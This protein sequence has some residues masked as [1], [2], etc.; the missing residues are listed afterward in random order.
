M[1]KNKNLE[2]IKR[3]LT[4]ISLFSVTLVFTIS[5]DRVL[6]SGS[7]NPTPNSAGEELA[8]FEEDE[9]AAFDQESTETVSSLLH[10]GHYKASVYFP[11]R[12]KRS[13][14]SHIWLHVIPFAG[15]V[16]LAITTA[17]FF[18]RLRQKPGLAVHSAQ[19]GCND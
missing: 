6:A 1:N 16:V 9:K 18:G 7:I 4:A 3:A 11:E 10:A 19:E 14:T 8:T 5:P 2:S 17:R 15:L 13:V 12:Q